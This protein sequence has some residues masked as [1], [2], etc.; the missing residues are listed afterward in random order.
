MTKKNEVVAVGQKNEVASYNA[1]EWGDVVVEAKD[2]IL[3]K[4]LLQQALSEAVKQRVARDGDY[5]NTLLGAVCSNEKG[6][7][8]ILP[9]YCRQSY[10]IEKFNGK[11]FE[12]L[13]VAPNIVGEQKPFEETIEG[14]RYKNSHQY[15]FFCRLEEGG[16]PA[17]VS[18]KSTSHK[19]GKQLFNL[20]YLQN[21]QQK[22][23]PAHNWI[24]L[25]RK[26]QTNDMGTFWVME[27]GVGKESNANEVSECLTWI[28]TIRQSDFKVAE[29]QKPS[30][31]QAS[32]SRF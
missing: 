17:I 11:K 3:P 4:I 23:T 25:G 9:F 19:T 29:E 2:L 7:V 18:F 20:M 31:Q 10:I 26:E 32:E 14:V 27:I 15:E 22:K 28:S 21:P 8:N 5:I 24:T 30:T 16:T 12:F 13:K 6:I 1:N